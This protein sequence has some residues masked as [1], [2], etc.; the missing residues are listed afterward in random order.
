MRQYTQGRR[1]NY[2]FETDRTPWQ[3]RASNTKPT[4]LNRERRVYLRSIPRPTPSQGIKETR[5]R[6]SIRVSRSSLTNHCSRFLMG[7][8]EVTVE[9]FDLKIKGEN[10]AAPF[11]FPP[12]PPSPPSPPPS[13]P[14][15][16]PSLYPPPSLS[17]PLFPVLAAPLTILLPFPL[18]LPH[19]S[20]PRNSKHIRRRDYASSPFPRLPLPPSPS[21]L[22]PHSPLPL[23]L[24]FSVKGR[25]APGRA[26]QF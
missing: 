12:P 17:S 3:S 18:L 24:S 11:S 13:P 5:R 6:L 2:I 26:R 22:P 7:K 23:P 16:S 20:P 4:A 25:E 19:P 8:A 15:L 9:C 14:L 21:A 1:L 10:Q